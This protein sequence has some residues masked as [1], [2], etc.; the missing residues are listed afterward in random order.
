MP[1][2]S[3]SGEDS[4]VLI[5]HLR[6]QNLLSFGPDFPGI[7]LGPLN[8]L[9]G[10]N[11]SGKSNLLQAIGLLQAMPNDL[12]RFFNSGGGF[13]RWFYSASK[14]EYLLITANLENNVSRSTITHHLDITG[15]KGSCIVSRENY[16]LGDLWTRGMLGGNRW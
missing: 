15:L 11:G 5:K 4:A 1:E 8:V 10:A 14:E 13:S 6:P 16:S 2:K 7:D 12:Q 9:I 3:Q